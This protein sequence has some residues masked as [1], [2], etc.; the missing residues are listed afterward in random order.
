VSRISICSAALVL[1]FGINVSAWGAREAPAAK[2]LASGM[3]RMV[4]SGPM[5][6]LVISGGHRE[7]YIEPQ[8]Q[9]KLILF[10]QQTVTVKG[11]EYFRELTFA[12]GVPAGRQYYLKN[13]KIIREKRR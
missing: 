2:V 11:R 8:E 3:V 6:S 12:N 1:L 5:R 7:W 9:K 13:I 10:Q 4:G